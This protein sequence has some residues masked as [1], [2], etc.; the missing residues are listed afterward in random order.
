MLQKDLPMFIKDGRK[1]ICRKDFYL[2]ID[3]TRLS[4]AGALILDFDFEVLFGGRV[5]RSLIPNAGMVCLAIQ[6]LS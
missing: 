4:P 6:H 3:K 5:D 2:E 1:G